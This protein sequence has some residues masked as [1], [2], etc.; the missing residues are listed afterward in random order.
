MQE[1]GF[2]D[3]QERAARV[4]A[5]HSRA[6]RKLEGYR[7]LESDLDDLETLEKRRG[8]GNSCRRGA[9]LDVANWRHDVGNIVRGRQAPAARRLPPELEAES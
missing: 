3:D 5:E 6:Q 1:P 9:W 8:G 4:S 7:T 2:W